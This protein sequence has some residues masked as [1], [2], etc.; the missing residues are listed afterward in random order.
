VKLF[1]LNMATILLAAPALFA[2]D[3]LDESYAALKKAVESKDAAQVKKLDADIHKMVSDELSKPAPTDP[4]EKKA[5]GERNEYIKSVDEY[6]EYA[7]FATALQLPA[8]EQVDM[9]ATLEA[10]NPKSK[11]LDEGYGGY[12]LALTQSGAAASKITAIAEKGLAAIPDQPDLLFYMANAT[13][14]KQPDRALTYANRLIA[15]MNKR[16]KPEN[17]SAADWEKKK[18]VS[19]G[20]GYWIAGCIYAT[21]NQYVN[22]DKDL[23]AALP[24]I[25]GNDGE[26]GP[27]LFYLGMVNYQLGK[28]TNNKAKVLEAAKFSEE[29][30][31]IPGPVADQARHN[32]IAMKND[33]QAMR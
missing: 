7:L 23:R 31:A 20:R 12:I 9:F 2:W 10:Q 18:A 13:L 26:T 29:S 1:A 16:A 21:K 8:A 25:K 19:L 17:L 22:A 6:T 27:A 30:A 28:M 32:A 5:W 4:D 15:S 24:L 33:A 3:Q 14:Q 11:Y